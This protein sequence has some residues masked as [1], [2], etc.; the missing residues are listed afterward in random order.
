MKI[1]KDTNV[2]EETI[3]RLNWFFDEF[4]N[5]VVGFS[6]GKDST[7]IFNMCMA[8]AEQRNRLPL[9]V[10]FLDQEGEWQA[11]IDMVE[12]VMTDPRVEPY[13]LQI[14][15]RISNAT[16]THGADWLMC[17]EEGAKWIR[18]KHPISLK[19]NPYGTM[20]FATIFTKFM[21][22]HFPKTKSCYIS[23]VR[24]EESPTRFCALTTAQTYKHV[25]YG[26]KLNPK[27]GH[28]TFYPLYDWSYTDIWKA[29]HENGWDYNR[30][31]D[32]QYQHGIKVLDMRVSNINHETALVHLKYMS[33]VERDTW[34][35]V[36][37]RIEGANTVKHLK[38]DHGKCP[39]EL[40]YMFESWPEYRDHLLKY[41][42]KDEHKG[43]FRKKFDKMEEVFG[44]IHHK[45]SMYRVQITA[46]LANDYHM[47]KIGNW[48]RQGDVNT[49]RKWKTGKIKEICRYNKYYHG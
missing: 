36:S 1:Y 18:E 22:Y 27:L 20:T 37:E 16:N 47:M 45:D 42:I 35:A 29:I 19:K 43:T 9:K 21:E 44:E 48:E 39:A 31:Y 23:G 33:E 11:T 7:V 17:W 24:C 41:L 32:Y 15:F 8:I 40:P 14:P 34:N 30:I 25:T 2:Y 46:L 38:D 28:Y 12:S 6:G 10:M 4:P 13:W 26:K 49:Y 3:K 5:V